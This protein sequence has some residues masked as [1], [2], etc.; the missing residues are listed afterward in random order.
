M[1]IPLAVQVFLLWLKKTEGRDKLYRLLCYSSKI[2]IYLLD[3]IKNADLASRLKSGASSVGLS[4][5]LLRLFRSIQFFQDF[6][7]SFEVQDSIERVIASTKSAAF[8][9][10][11][12]VDHAQWM[13]KVGYIKQDPQTIA[14]LTEIHSKAWFFGLLLGALQASYKLM[15]PQASKASKEKNIKGL[16]KNSTDLIV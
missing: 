6:L 7:K 1:E 3:P 8:T 5:K 12:L 10:W 2:P 13:Q 16:L 14:R 11:M 4:R 15:G 9:V